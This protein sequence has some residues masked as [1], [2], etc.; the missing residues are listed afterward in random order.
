MARRTGLGKLLREQLLQ[1]LLF[2]LSGGAREAQSDRLADSLRVVL[3]V[4]DLVQLARHL[5]HRR[6]I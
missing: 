2:S 3:R 5:V 6:A 1:S 4:D